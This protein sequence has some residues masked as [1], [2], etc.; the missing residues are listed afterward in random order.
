MDTAKLDLLIR[1]KFTEREMDT[2]VKLAQLNEA[3]QEIMRLS[4]ELQTEKV[5]L[6]VKERFSEDALN[7]LDQL[8]NFLALHR[9]ICDKKKTT[10]DEERLTVLDKAREQMNT[11]SQQFNE[12]AGVCALLHNIK[13]KM[14]EA[15]SISAQLTQTIDELKATVVVR[16][17]KETNCLVTTCEHCNEEVSFNLNDLQ[18]VD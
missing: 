6:L 10:V 9:L 8:S 1:S 4:S 3:M 12:L 11:L 14:S 17:N 16:Y 15:E 18:L 7:K 2:L 13:I 5:E